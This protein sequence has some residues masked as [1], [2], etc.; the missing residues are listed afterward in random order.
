MVLEKLKHNASG[1]LTGIA[2][3][4]V[5]TTAY[6]ASEEAEGAKEAVKAKQPASTYEHLMAILPKR[7]K[8]IVSAGITTACIVASHTID[9]RDMA[10]LAGSCAAIGGTLSRYKDVAKR[11]LSK[12]DY[13]ELEERFEEEEA[14]M[15][16][17]VEVMH[18][19]YEPVT[20][21]FFELSWKD[22]WEAI[23][24]AHKIL[25]LEGGLKF[26]DFLYF[27]GINRKPL[28]DSCGWDTGD[29]ICEYDYAWLDIRLEE[30]NNPEKGTVDYNFNDG[31][32]TYELVYDVTPARMGYASGHA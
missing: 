31:R 2:C 10:K 19:F 9:M 6:F 11:Y 8:T 30:R 13:D 25:A 18:W 22:Y 1:I 7:K 14:E 17:D 3:L 24:D 4:G 20:G 16:S 23:D 28:P 12:E 27:L 5:L 26:N 21:N 32:P 15:H 29:L